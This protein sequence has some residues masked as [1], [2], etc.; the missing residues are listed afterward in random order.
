MY[1]TLN[2]HVSDIMH[3]TRIPARYKRGVGCPEESDAYQR[4]RWRQY[5]NLDI[6]LPEQPTQNIYNS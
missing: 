5:S 4:V 6:V 2:E 3:S 1:I